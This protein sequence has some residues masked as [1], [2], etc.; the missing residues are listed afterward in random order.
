[1]SVH[2]SMSTSEV[3]RTIEAHDGVNSFKCEYCP[4]RFFSRDGLAKHLNSHTLAHQCN[5]CSQKL[6]TKEQ[7]VAHQ[8]NHANDELVCHL[9]SRVY[10]TKVMF[11]RHIRSHDV[12]HGCEHCG[13]TF[14][15]ST[16]LRG[17]VQKVHLRIFHYKCKFCNK[18]FHEQGGLTR[19][20]RMHTG[21]KP[22]SCGICDKKFIMKLELER[23]QQSKHMDKPIVCQLCGKTFGYR[24]LLQMH[25]KWTHTDEK[26]HACSYCPYRGKSKQAL[27]T[28]ELTHTGGKPHICPNKACNKAFRTRSQLNTHNL[29]HT[30]ALPW[31]CDVCHQRFRHKQ[32]MKAHQQTHAS[33]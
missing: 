32:A 15:N 24:K 4:S 1:M 14:P 10:K 23:H 26:P 31:E 22:F 17:H 3:P 13:K 11:D 2:L 33:S 25:L 16:R 6:A 7:L 30:G 5:K 8:E 9:C 20:E 28:H 19:H 29:I 18:G 21:E 12:V 27:D